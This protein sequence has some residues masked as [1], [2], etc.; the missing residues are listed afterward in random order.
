MAE[1]AGR[2]DG[3]ALGI[4][5]EIR[6][7]PER[8]Q[9]LADDLLERCRGEGPANCVGRCPL[10]VDARGYVQLA[11]EGRFQDALR[12]V[13]EQLPFPGVLGYVC[14]HPCELHCKRIDEDEAVRIRDIKRFLAEWEPGD[15]QHM[16]DCAADRG[17]QVAVVGAGPAGLL[18]AYD[19]RR[20]GYGVTI[21]ERDGE[22]GGCLVSKIPEWRLP[23]TVVERDLSVIEAVGIEVRTGVEVGL[24]VTLEELRREFAAVLLLVG[25]A[26]ARA[27][28]RRGDQGVGPRGTLE[29][30]PLT[31]ETP[32]EGVFAGGDAVSGP[33]TVVYAMALGRRAAESADRYLNGRD[34]RED[35]EQPLPGRLLWTLEVTEEERKRRE[36]TPMMLV[37]ANPPMIEEEVLE[38]AA[39]CLDCEC[40]LCVK[41]CEFLAKHCSSPKELARRI[42]AGVTPSETLE[43][44]YSCN[45]CSLCAAVC[46]EDLDTGR[47]LL[48]A[49]R[50]AVEE[51]VGPLP[52][53]KGIVG[54]WKAGVGSMFT[55]AM[56]EPGR[57]SSKRLFFTGCA[58]PAVAPRHTI[59]V[60]DELR[61][62]YPGTG[63]LMYCC[64][65]PV[66]L[67]G[68]EKE[69]EETR[70]GILE[71]AES[72]GAEE[73]VAA[74]PDCTHTLKER[75]PELAVTTVWELL[76]DAWEPPRRRE[77]VVVSVHDSCKARHEPGLHQAVRTLIEAGGGTV[78][79][80]EYNRELARCCGFG[81]MIYPVDP[82]LSQTVTR[83]RAG[84]TAQPQVTYCAGCRS[85]LASIGK[86]SIHI[87]DFLLE[88]DWSSRASAKPTGTIARYWNRLRTKWAFKR[89]RPLG[90]E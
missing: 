19:L 53:H 40:G 43:M 68:M 74:C 87:L 79:D 27:M 26:G 2:L 47:L 85:A 18:A 64:G 77:G 17:Q 51:G 28:M 42:K 69:F 88:K 33:A 78:E 67:L 48:E 80:I 41:D 6:H 29:V 61:R 72:I 90:V 30:D 45:V 44:A 62:S 89:L 32:L 9:W 76:A 20:K 83:R 63:V 23:R 21:F 66:E 4:P 81:G 5:G 13:R 65:A 70:R 34:L 38:E 3:S 84:E 16:V 39:R 8:L 14:A 15:P 22:I 50:Q 54:Y 86:P 36:R 75:F 56:A 46:P 52:V 11:R 10:H 73:L 7:E 57:R 58:L 25:F 60:Y 12:L 49:R 55:L 24:D 31:C 82:E 71:A 35:R 59:A 1:P 37:P